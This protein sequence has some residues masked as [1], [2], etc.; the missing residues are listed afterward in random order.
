MSGTNF[1]IACLG[2]APDV[3]CVDLKTN[4]KLNL[5][6]SLLED[7]PGDVPY[8]LGRAERPK[9]PT[10]G[11]TVRSFFHD[12]VPQLVESLEKKLLSTYGSNTALVLRQ[13]SIIWGP[14]EW[15]IVADEFRDEVLR[16]KEKHYGA[17]V[18]IICTDN[19]TWPASDT[20][21]CL[22]ESI[23]DG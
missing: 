2:D 13:V 21:F 6:I 22:S 16:G 11:T 15:G 14:F 8:A 17:G 3:E 1:E 12:S 23:S 5:E 19:S 4:G 7:L 18:W 9:S 10:T 20:L